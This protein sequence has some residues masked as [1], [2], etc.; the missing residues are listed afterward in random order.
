MNSRCH[1]RLAT[2]SLFGDVSTF[3]VPLFC[4]GISGVPAEV[5]ASR[6]AREGWAAQTGIQ[7][8]GNDDYSP[9]CVL[10]WELLT[11]SEAFRMR[12]E[13]E[14]LLGSFLRRIV[15][16]EKRAGLLTNVYGS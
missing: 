8:S 12:M 2:D 7:A 10:R 9:G 16:K 3:C 14:K 13:S 4:S 5:P 1:F 15:V 6:N 11:F